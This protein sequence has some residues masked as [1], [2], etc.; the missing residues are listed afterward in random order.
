MSII[1]SIVGNLSTQKTR[2]FKEHPKFLIYH[3]SSEDNTE[4]IRI[5]ILEAVLKLTISGPLL[6]ELQEEKICL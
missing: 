2:N 3:C 1:F 4:C 5:S 6:F